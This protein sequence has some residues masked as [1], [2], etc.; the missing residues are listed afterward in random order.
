M[1]HPRLSRGGASRLPRPVPARRA[2][3]AAIG[4]FVA[5]IPIERDHPSAM[6]S[7]GSRT[8]W[9]T[10]G[11][12]P[13]LLL[14]GSADPVF[15]DRFLHDFER[16]LPHA[17]VHRYAKAGHLVSEDADAV[18][19]IVDWIGTLEGRCDPARADVVRR[20]WK[21][22]GPTVR[23]PRTSRPVCSTPMATSVTRSPSSS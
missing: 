3:R 21:A 8:V 1:S 14:W 6:F 11:Q 19:A 15:S 20:R 5:D 23:G 4:D 22:Y 10:M 2:G 9:P 13:V 16:R 7:T 18:G 12:V 17:V